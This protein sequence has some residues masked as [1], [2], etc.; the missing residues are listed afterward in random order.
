M[1]KAVQMEGKV[2]LIMGGTTEIG[3][4]CVREMLMAGVGAVM[5]ADEDEQ[6]GREVV[7]ELSDEYGTEKTAFIRTDFRCE[8]LLKNAFER[9]LEHFRKID[10]LVN[11]VNPVGGSNWKTEI[12]KNVK[13]IVQCTLLGYKYMNAAKGGGGGSV[14]NMICDRESMIPTPY[15][16]GCRHYLVAFG[17]SMSQQNHVDTGVKVVTLFVNVDRLENQKACPTDKGR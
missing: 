4:L 10:V 12:D 14:L 6:R 7:I 15:F 1:R 16:E 5:I 11:I 8:N 3:V 2:A 17:K 13:G 9:T